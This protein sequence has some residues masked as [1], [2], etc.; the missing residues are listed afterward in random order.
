MDLQ[1]ETLSKAMISCTFF[2][3]NIQEKVQGLCF[4][5][6]QLIVVF[7]SKICEVNFKEFPV[8]LTIRELFDTK[9]KTVSNLIEKPLF[10][11]DQSSVYFLLRTFNQSSTL[12]CRF[13]LDQ[14]IHD[15][16]PLIETIQKDI[17]FI[18]FDAKN[19]STVFLICSNQVFSYEM[20]AS[21]SIQDPTMNKYFHQVF[22]TKDQKPKET[23]P[24]NITLLYENQEQVINAFVLHTQTDHFFTHD[25]KII[26]KI[27]LQ[28][29]YSSKEASGHN[30]SVTQ[31]RLNED[32]GV[33]FR[34]RES[35]NLTQ[36]VT[37]TTRS[38]SGIKKAWAS[39]RLSLASF[40][41]GLGAP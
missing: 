3:F 27:P 20:G 36:A 11:R 7:Q 31:L 1:K 15:K 19:S 40:D 29:R 34:Y 16:K 2:G 21:V 18:A 25:G 30:T 26:K 24:Q 9:A 32:W 6:E 10:S 17:S 23:N 8:S 35:L 13:Y 28:D 12:I 14:N 22:S 38:K 37:G 4:L 33:L 41:L 5:G 39:F